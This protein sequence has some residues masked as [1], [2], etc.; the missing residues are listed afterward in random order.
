MKTTNLSNMPFVQKFGARVVRRYAIIWFAALYALLT[1]STAGL[2]LIS[3]DFTGT[4]LRAI[5]G[6]LIA[7]LVVVAASLLTRM[8]LEFFAGI[9]RLEARP[10][11]A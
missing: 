10:K 9:E 1:A 8:R 5:L 7:V 3:P 4:W 11:A 2:W 6:S